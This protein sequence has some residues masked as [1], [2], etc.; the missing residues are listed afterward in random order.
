MKRRLEARVFG[1][2]QGVGFRF[3]VH[4]YA[5][6]YNISG[7]VKNNI[8]GTVTFVGEGEE[9]DL[10]KM[11]NHLHEGPIGAEVREVKFEWKDFKD[12]FKNFSIK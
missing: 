5:K 1:I 6:K 4:Y 12:E 9:E 3:F 2:V 7:F 8:D 10:K 11:L